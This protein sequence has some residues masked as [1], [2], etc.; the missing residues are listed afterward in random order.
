MHNLAAASSGSLLP[1]PH[2]A[3]AALADGQSPVGSGGG[4][5]SSPLRAR[6]GGAGRLLRAGAHRSVGRGGAGGRASVWRTTV[7]RAR[8]GGGGVSLAVA[9]QVRS[10]LTGSWRRAAPGDAMA[11]GFLEWLGLWMARFAGGRLCR[12]A[13][14]AEVAARRRWWSR[15][16]LFLLYPGA[17]AGGGSRWPVGWP[18]A[19][20]SQAG[21][22]WQER[23]GEGD[24]GA[25]RPWNRRN[26]GGQI[27]CD[28]W[29]AAWLAPADEFLL[30]RSGRL[31]PATASRLVL[32]Q[33]VRPLLPLTSLRRPWDLAAVEGRSQG[34]GPGGGRHGARGRSSRLG[35]SPVAMAVRVAWW[36][37]YGV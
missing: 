26:L 25:S 11:V 6:P 34:G 18:N 1:F 8:C 31:G 10:D 14:L 5:A 24:R 37:G 7:A 29:A 19:P 30:S 27:G 2:L 17:K 21:R 13:R 12:G 9:A 23:L 36:P 16:P 20:A 15:P 33:K 3:A 22:W 28:G 35:C 32:G 4:G